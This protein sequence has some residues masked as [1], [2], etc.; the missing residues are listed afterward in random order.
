MFNKP[1]KE[2][3]PV[4]R[5]SR[6]RASKASSFMDRLPSTFI[7]HI[8]GTKDV[9][10]DGYCGFRCVA[11]LVGFPQESWGRVRGELYHELSKNCELYERVFIEKKRVDKIL[12]ALNWYDETAPKKK[13]FMLPE[14]GHLTASYYNVALITLSSAQSLTFLPIRSSIPN[15]VVPKVIC[16]AFV[17]DNHFIQVHLKDGHPLPPV[18]LQWNIIQLQKQSLGSHICNTD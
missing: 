7:A 12:E 6:T 17:N 1:K 2:K 16:I 4:S 11:E 14:M 15:D 10:G 13:W 5:C 8:S 9:L 18:V 3:L